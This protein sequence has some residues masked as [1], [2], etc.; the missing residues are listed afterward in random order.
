MDEYTHPIVIS[1][2]LSPTELALLIIILIGVLLALIIPALSAF[3]VVQ[4]TNS[5]EKGFTAGCLTGLRGTGAVFIVMITNMVITRATC[6][7]SAFLGC[8]GIPT[9]IIFYICFTGGSFFLGC[10][11]G[12]IG[13][14]GGKG[15][16]KYPTEDHDKPNI[17]A[18]VSACLL[19]ACFNAARYRPVVARDSCPSLAWI[20]LI[21]AP[22]SSIVRAQ[23]WRVT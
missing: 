14:A 21:L 8:I 11:G 7:P 13:A 5:F 15:E 1:I 16:V 18:S 22:A 4:Q 20:S 23:V 6:D 10:L 12:L 3:A 19:S 9:A 17:D 2:Y